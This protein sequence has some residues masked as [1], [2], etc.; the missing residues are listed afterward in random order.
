MLEYSELLNPRGN[1]VIDLVLFIFS[2][3]AFLDSAAVIGFSL[4]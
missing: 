2:E 4:S 3:Y 1:A